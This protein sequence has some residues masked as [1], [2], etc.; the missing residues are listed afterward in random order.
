MTKKKKRQLENKTSIV[1]F[2]GFF[3]AH[4]VSLIVWSSIFTGLLMQLFNSGNVFIALVIALLINIMMS[5]LISLSAFHLYQRIAD[6]RIF[7]LSYALF[8]IILFLSVFMI[9]PLGD[10]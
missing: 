8:T 1:F 2:S 4:F 5:S 9:L 6:K 7:W 10:I 3:I